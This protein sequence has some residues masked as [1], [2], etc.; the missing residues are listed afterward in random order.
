MEITTGLSAPPL[1]RGRNILVATGF[2]VA[3]DPHVGGAHDAIGEAVPAS[4]NVVEF[5]HC[6]AIAPVDRSDCLPRGCEHR[7][8]IL[9]RRRSGIR[10]QR[11]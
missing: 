5:G 2:A 7:E 8:R 3:A 11:L 4:V 9:R 1:V 10:G 6:H